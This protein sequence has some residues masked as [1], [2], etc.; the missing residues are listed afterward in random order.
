MMA[1]WRS[2]AVVMVTGLASGTVGSVV[3][4][5]FVKSRAQSPVALMTE[6]SESPKPVIIPPGWDLALV[7]RLANVEQKLDDLR[8]SAPEA[9]GESR[10][11]GDAGPNDEE[12]Q[13]RQ[14]A[15]DYQQDLD[16][17]D[18]ALADHAN[19]PSDGAWATPLATSMQQALGKAFDGTA[20][21]KSVDCRSKTCTATLTFPTPRD[22]LASLR[23][24]N[25]LVVQGCNGF[26]AIPT[27]PATAGPYDLTVVYNCR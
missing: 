5:H 8:A 15:A 23:Q 17:L 10:P 9:P 26:A 25:G 14:L 19:E 11:T 3:Y 16:Y 4:A 20:Q 2:T 1:G 21:T 13:K 12:A 24:P 7:S 27:P 22:A 18:K 6:R